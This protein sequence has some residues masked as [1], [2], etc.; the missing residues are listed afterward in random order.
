MFLGM[1]TFANNHVLQPSD[2]AE[3]PKT[4][5]NS[6]NVSYSTNA[7]GLNITKDRITG[8]AA[9]IHTDD[10]ATKAYVDE[11]EKFEANT[12][13]QRLS[14]SGNKLFLER[15]GHVQLPVLTDTNATTAC[16]GEEYLSGD[17]RCLVDSEGGS[18]DNQELSLSGD[19]LSIENGNNVNISTS[20][21]GETPN[22]SQ[23]LSQENSAEQYNLNMSG[24]NITD[25]GQIHLPDNAKN[26]KLANLNATSNM[27]F[28]DK[29]SYQ[30][31]INGERMLELKAEANGNGGL[32]GR[33]RKVVVGGVVR[34]RAGELIL[35]GASSSSNE[36]KIING[37]NL[38]VRN[39]DIQVPSGAIVADGLRFTGNIT[40]GN[41]STLVNA[42][43][44]LAIGRGATVGYSSIGKSVVIG[45]SASTDAQSS[46]AIGFNARSGKEG[47]AIG[48]NAD[49]SKGKESVV[50]GKSASADDGGTAVGYG[51]STS[52]RRSVAL[53]RS[54]TADGWRTTALGG[55]SLVST[56]NGVAVGR[57]AQSTALG[58]VAI[59]H[60]ALSDNEYTVTLGNLGSKRQ[61]LNVTGNTTVHGDAG[62]TVTD[63]DVQ[64]S[65]GAVAADQ[66]NV[67]TVMQL[68]QNTTAFPTC[69]SSRAGEL[70]RKSSNN[71]LYY[72]NGSVSW[73]QMD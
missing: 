34:A 9:P 11:T 20:S 33:G 66:V 37:H 24:N 56:S 8:L 26:H 69:S 18:S 60:K 31:N 47:I 10:A 73:Q 71:G 27:S 43:D 54:A 5:N 52:V 45:D 65:S 4:S 21:G 42:T 72:C 67:S 50:V 36:V 29:L 15:G 40:V 70:R 28:G 63:G 55:N 68:S 17:G 22:L 14:I 39:G 59:G 44:S 46:V 1:G 49:G 38:K 12:D 7:A 19:I 53:G 35:G 58:A 32:R 61:D 48:T 16:E 13:N 64:V 62:L 30:F 25:I 51:T 57:D 6:N 2:S 41:A 3:Q 23:V